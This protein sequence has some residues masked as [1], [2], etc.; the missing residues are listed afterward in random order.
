MDKWLGHGE[1]MCAWVFASVCTAESCSHTLAMAMYVVRTYNQGVL[2]RTCHNHISPIK[3]KFM[4]TQKLFCHQ[5]SSNNKYT[6]IYYILRITLIYSCITYTDNVWRCM[7][8][9]MLVFRVV[10]RR[11]VRSGAVLCVRMF[12]LQPDCVIYI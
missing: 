9:K 6:S 8:R 7:H 1:A 12:T 5:T 3:I 11:S 2:R 10:N 4:P